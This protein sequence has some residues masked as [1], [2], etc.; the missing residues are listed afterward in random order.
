[1]KIKKLIKTY[2]HKIIKI[3]NFLYKH[4]KTYIQINIKI[5]YTK[6]I[7]IKNKNI[8]N[9]EIKNNE[10]IYIT[11]FKKKK[12]CTILCNN[13]KKKTLL[14]CINYYKKNINQISKDKYNIL[15][16]INL[17]KKKYKKNLGIF[18]NDYINNINII[19]LCKNIEYNTINYNNKIFSDGVNF[20]E[21]I[22]INFIF[23][24]FNYMKYYINKYYI[25]I[26]N[27]YI[28]LPNN[29]MEYISKYIINHKLLDL[30][31][32]S[33][34]LPKNTCNELL[35]MKKI[36]HIKT[37]KCSIIF[38]NETSTE[39]FN[40][41]KISLKG[42]N[43]YHNISFMSK[44]LNKK[45]LP[46]WLSIIDNPNLFKGIGS[47]PFD[48]EG[49]NTYK[50]TLIKN[51]ILKTW[52]LNSKYSKKLNI[53][54]T[55]NSGGIHNWLFIKNKKQINLNELIKKMNNGLY[56]NKLLGQ[57]ININNG[58][59]SKGVSGYWIKNGKI[60]FYTNEIT[61]SGNLINLFKNIKNMSD[62]YNTN[63]KIMSGSILVNNIQITSNN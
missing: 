32:N 56:I 27:S 12:K 33:F 5:N 41:L 13:Y 22:Y 59:F 14:K 53:K 49:L 52:I 17:F 37:Q 63:S 19:N 8:E 11:F 62:D 34:N 51:G 50:Y 26:N 45:I 10:F 40:Y 15:P 16:S 54:N 43:I 20:Q 38:N 36:K 25:I 6:E 23:N 55:F 29:N 24:T 58:L 2:K 48:K 60:K 35:N 3:Y 21:N 18:F 28:K 42:H 47:K 39:I 44:K 4:T 46:N 1:M 61:I 57:G 30:I 9:I 31:Q 7:K